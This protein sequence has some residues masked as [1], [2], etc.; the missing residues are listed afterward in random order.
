MES[1]VSWDLGWSCSC[2]S[3]LAISFLNFCWSSCCRSFLN[4]LGSV[5][6]PES[7]GALLSR[8]QNL[9]RRSEG[10]T[11]NKQDDPYLPGA[12]FFVL[13]NRNIRSV[14]F[15][16]AMISVQNAGL[17]T[18]KPSFL[19]RWFALGTFG[20]GRVYE[21]S[22]LHVEWE[23]SESTDFLNNK[24]ALGVYSLACLGI[25]LMDNRYSLSRMQFPRAFPKHLNKS[26]LIWAKIHLH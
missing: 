16:T 3:F 4:C 2:C 14:N 17:E 12:I 19:Y 20:L 26:K 11:M 9:K 6:S 21:R 7:A 24:N 15:R 10:R 18:G 1:A 5:C 23:D 25:L 13:R 8:K 22:W